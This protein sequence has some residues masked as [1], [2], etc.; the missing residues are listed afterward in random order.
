MSEV[1]KTELKVVIPDLQETEP[2]VFIMETLSHDDEKNKR[3]EGV[4]LS[5]M[6]RLSG[7]NPKYYYF[8]TEEELPHVV[9]LFRASKYRYL[10]I[11]AHANDKSI[12]IGEKSITYAEFAKYFEGHLKLRRLFLSACSAGNID[13]VRS[14]S[15]ENNGMHSIIAPQEDILFSDAAAAWSTLYL[16]LFKGSSKS[17]THNGIKSRIKSIS[18]LF[19]IPFFFAGYNPTRDNWNYEVVTGD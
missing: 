13:F 3:Y 19:S 7:K 2:E 1:K 9:G 12:G 17:M 6:L 16:S 15:K 10:H 8:Q 18:S 14:I 11:S 5:D 4:I